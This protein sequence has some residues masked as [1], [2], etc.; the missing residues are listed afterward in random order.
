[1]GLLPCVGTSFSVLDSMRAPLFCLSVCHVAPGQPHYYICPLWGG[2]ETLCSVAQ[3]G[4]L[5]NWRDLLALGDSHLLR[6]VILPPLLSLSKV[7]FHPA[8]DCIIF[9]DDF[10]TKMQWVEVLG[11]LLLMTG[12][13]WTL[14]PCPN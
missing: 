11:F 1:M 12:T 5:Q 7:L 10:D 4:C 9:L 8:S 14:L 2:D 3:E 6:K 13:C